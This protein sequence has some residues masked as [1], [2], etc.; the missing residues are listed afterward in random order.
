[1]EPE[2]ESICFE[3]ISQGG[4][5]RSLI[6]DALSLAREGD[7]AGAREKIQ[8]SRE[9][10]TAA[11]KLQLKLLQKEASGESVSN[12]VLLVHAQ[13]ILMASVTERDLSELIITLFERIKTLEKAAA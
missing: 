1:M 2:L 10:M 11:H 4:E 9:P 8:K 6:F 5:A 12:C 13:D 3:I 7:I